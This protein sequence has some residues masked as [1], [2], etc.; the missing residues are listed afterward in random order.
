[1]QPPPLF[2]EIDFKLHDFGARGTSSAESAG[3]GGM[4]H[5]VNFKGTDT[6]VGLQTAIEHYGAA[7]PG[8]SIPATEHSTVTTH[9]TELEAFK[10]FLDLHPTGIIACVSDSYDIRNAVANLWAKELK[11]QILFVALHEGIVD[12]EAIGRRLAGWAGHVSVLIVQR[13][14][15][16]KRYS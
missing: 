11:G 3:V 10:H 1:M 16:V 4:A 2:G 8:F 6:G 14:T 13:G 7:M 9:P 5:L 12:Y 15:V